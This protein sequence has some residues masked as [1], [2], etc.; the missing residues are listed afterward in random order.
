MKEW[1]ENELIR[2]K[3]FFDKV[4]KQAEIDALSL[5]EIRELAAL[6]NKKTKVFHLKIK[7]Q[8]E[9]NKIIA[10]DQSSIIKEK[11]EK[12]QQELA[13]ELRDAY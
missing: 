7:Q 1:E 11:L 5:K 3:K 13:Q 2:A 12:S 8:A 4:K 9:I 6:D 10:E